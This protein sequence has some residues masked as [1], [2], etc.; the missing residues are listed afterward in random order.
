MKGQPQTAPNAGEACLRRDVQHSQ[1]VNTAVITVQDIG[2]GLIAFR[3]TVRPDRSLAAIGVIV[4]PERHVIDY[5][6]VEV[7]I[8]VSIEECCSC[9]P[10]AIGNTC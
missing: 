7:A 10:T 4:E 5:R 8:E 3:V 1:T 6:K 9:P 2:G